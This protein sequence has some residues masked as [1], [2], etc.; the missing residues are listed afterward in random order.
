MGDLLA[1][2]KPAVG[3]LKSKRGGAEAAERCAEK[4]FVKFWGDRMVL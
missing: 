4:F 2:I 3:A 1:T